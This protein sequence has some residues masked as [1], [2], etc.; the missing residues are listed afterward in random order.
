M[1]I[2]F[3]EIVLGCKKIMSETLGKDVKIT[4]VMLFGSQFPDFWTCRITA[5]DFKG[6]KYNY[7][8]LC[9]QQGTDIVNVSK[10]VEELPLRP[11]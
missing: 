7:V 9:S 8:M 2:N 10:P 1:H 6:K 4:G 11:N 3:D 5:E